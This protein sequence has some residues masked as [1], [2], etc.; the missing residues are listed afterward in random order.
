MSNDKEQPDEPKGEPD[1]EQAF[2]E[3]R[4]YV[5]AEILNVSFP[6]AVRGYDRRA[7]DAHI[8]R[9][10]RLI[11]EIKAGAS[12]RA[13]VRH[14]LEQTEQ[15]VS[16]LLERARETADEIT[17]SANREAEA[18]ANGIRAKAA[19]LLVNANAEADA[20][21]TEAEKLLADSKAEAETV[22]SNARAEA[23]DIL[24]RSRLEAEN[25]V[26]RAQGEAD[27]RLQR[28][29]A[30]LAS[31]R[32]QTEARMRGFQADTTRFGE[33]FSYSIRCGAWRAGSSLADAATPE[34]PTSRT[35]SR[36]WSQRRKQLSRK[37]PTA[38]RRSRPCRQSRPTSPLTARLPKRQRKLPP[39]TSRNRRSRPGAGRAKGARKRHPVGFRARLSLSGGSAG[40]T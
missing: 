18:E 7:V 22:L 14:A 34:S 27:E 37:L 15:Q 36:R 10:N 6:A 25:T 29:Q 12:P 26:K 20:T 21:K 38:A 11:A 31:L 2:G 5:P 8:K 9:V 39:A 17:T 1:Q 23:E 28:L 32:D 24:V 16:G 19:E 3:L 13:A 40:S 30:E 35:C 33:R 4:H